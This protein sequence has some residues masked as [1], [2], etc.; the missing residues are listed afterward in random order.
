[1]VYYSMLAGKPP[2]V[3]EPQSQKMIKEGIPPFVDPTWN[4]GFVEVNT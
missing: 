3:D 1:M 2:F 4:T